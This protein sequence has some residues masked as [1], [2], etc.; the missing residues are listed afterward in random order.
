MSTFHARLIELESE[1]IAKEEALRGVAAPP[2]ECELVLESVENGLSVKLADVVPKDWR[3]WLSYRRENLQLIISRGRAFKEQGLFAKNRAGVDVPNGLDTV[4]EYGRGF[5]VTPPQ[6]I[7][8]LMVNFGSGADSSIK[9]F[10]W[11]GEGIAPYRLIF[12][13]ELTC[14]DPQRELTDAVLEACQWIVNKPKELT[15]P[16]FLKRTE[17]S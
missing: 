10:L 8:H 16:E 3:G 6:D 9:V 11:Y 2:P 17:S 1:I 12:E 15:L 4:T 13:E 5:D 7:D 14:C